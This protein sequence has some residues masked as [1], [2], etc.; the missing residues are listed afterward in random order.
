VSG[1]CEPIDPTALKPPLAVE[2]ITYNWD[3]QLT[4]PCPSR[5][6]SEARRTE[7]GVHGGPSW[8]SRSRRFTS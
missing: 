4:P 8:S 5:F 6:T 2:G 1:A 7:R 3:P